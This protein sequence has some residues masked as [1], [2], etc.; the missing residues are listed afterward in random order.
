MFAKALEA[1]G[2]IWQYD[3]VQDLAG[4]L[5]DKAGLH[6][7][8]D[9]DFGLRHLVAP[10]PRQIRYDRS[11][12]ELPESLA[13]FAARAQRQQAQQPAVSSGADSF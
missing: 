6:V 11:S 4:L 2:Y 3:D 1:S 5:K 7:S 9:V 12:R 8:A 13:D 10:A